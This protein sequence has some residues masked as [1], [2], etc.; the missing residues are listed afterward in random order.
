MIYYQS[1]PKEPVLL[2]DILYDLAE[3]YLLPQ[4]QDSLMGLYKIMVDNPTFVIELRSHTGRKTYSYDKRHL[5][6]TSCSILC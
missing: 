6:A 4:Y 3:W 1:I 2:P 5:I